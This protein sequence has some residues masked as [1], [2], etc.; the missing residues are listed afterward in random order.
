MN[1]LTLAQ[2]I[3]KLPVGTNLPLVL[4]TSMGV[5]TDNPEFVAAGFATCLT[6][7]IKPAQLFESLVRVVSGLRTAPKPTP[8]NNKLNPKLSNRL[9][10]RVLLCD[11]NLINQKV[12]TRVLSQM[13][14]S[15]KVA[16]NG[17]EALKAIDDAMFDLIFMDVMM[18]EMDGLE[19]TRQIRLRQNNRAAHPNYKSAIVIVAM[20]ASAMPGDKEKCLAAGMDDY[21]SKP[22]RPEEMRAVIE[23]WGE[24]AALDLAAHKN[25]SAM[26]TANL[27]AQTEKPMNNLPA[28]D[29]DRLNEFT[30][31]NPENLTELAT[32]Y[33]KQTTQQLEQLQTAVKTSDATGSAASRTAVLA[34]APPAA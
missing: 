27:L 7:P 23:R 14:Y 6:K 9:P 17:L 22:V 8:G 29:M 31:G 18:P 12:A 20:T 28:V 16:G 2:E 3:R 33:L 5:R 1:G 21:L 26:A 15:A 30:E 19:A 4:L 11:D 10:L 24:K 25:D 13:G 32:L 34:R